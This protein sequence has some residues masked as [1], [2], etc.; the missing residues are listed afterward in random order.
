MIRKGRIAAGRVWGLGERLCRDDF[1]RRWILFKY[2]VKSVIEYGAEIWGWSEI[3]ELEKVMLDYIRWV[4]RLDFCTPRYVILKELKLEKLK[5]D[6]G[7]RA[8]RYEKRSRESKDKNLIRLCWM[9][10]DKIIKGKGDLHRMERER[11]Y[12]D[13]GWSSAVIKELNGEGRDMEGQIRI[14]EQDIQGQ[15]INSKIAKARYNKRYREIGLSNEAPNYLLE[16]NLEKVRTGD[17]IRAKVKVRCGN[18]EETNKYW[19]REEDLRCKFCKVGKDNLEHYVGECK[20]VSMWF[21]NLGRNIKE[22]LRNVCD[23]KYK[24]EKGKILNKLWKRR[25]ECK[26]MN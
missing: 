19:L 23:D 26:K 25:E 24:A 11:Y 21:E 20:V 10:K 17:E 7:L 18:L 4:Y 5:I 15:I 1:I 13:K 8:T 12:N 22:R 6:W 2:L 9:E 16:G 14:R 3:K